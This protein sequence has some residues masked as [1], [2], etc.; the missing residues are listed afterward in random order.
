MA[1]R[2]RINRDGLGISTT[3]RRSL[4]R[5]CGR[6]DWI[7]F[8]LNRGRKICPSSIST[9]RRGCQWRVGRYYWPL[10]QCFYTF[11]K[12]SGMY[13]AHPSAFRSSQHVAFVS[14]EK[15]GLKHSSAAWF[16]LS[17]PQRPPPAPAS[18]PLSS[19]TSRLL[20]V[21]LSSPVIQGN[22]QTGPTEGSTGVGFAAA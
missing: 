13:R 4:R 14:M 17:P 7:G 12:I 1:I 15:T 9:V 22:K 3:Y 16:P 8:A 19:I 2:Q 18:I 5:L 21:I 10:F 20:F 6:G 11:P